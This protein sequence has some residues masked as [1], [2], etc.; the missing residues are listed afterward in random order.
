MWPVRNECHYQHACAPAAANL[1]GRE[2]PLVARDDGHTI[3]TVEAIHLRHRS[4]GYLTETL[5]ASFSRLLHAAARRA[6]ALQTEYPVLGPRDQEVF[7]L[8]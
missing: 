8:G 4:A 2:A 1:Q 3:D 6:R 5:P 7:C